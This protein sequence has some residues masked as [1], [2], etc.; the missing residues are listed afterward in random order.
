MLGTN[1]TPAPTNISN[2]LGKRQYE[3]SNHLGNVQAVVLDFKIPVDD[4]SNSTAN[5]IADYYIA[6][7]V[8]AQ[9]YYPFGMIMPARDFSSSGYRYGFNSEEKDDE[10]KG[11]GNSY[12]FKFRIYDPRL[13]KFLSIDPFAKSYAWNSPYAFAEN[14]V[15]RAIDLEGLEKYIVTARAFIPMEKVYNPQY[16]PCISP[17]IPCNPTKYF[18]GD[19]RNFYSVNS[20]A[21][22]TEQKV[23]V[24]F[25]N[26]T[27]TKLNNTAS[28]ST[29]LAS[30]GTT[31][32]QTSSLGEAGPTPTYDKPALESGTS[33][34]VYL[35]VNASNKLAPGA[36]SIDYYLAVTITP[37]VNSDGSPVLDKS[38]NQTFDYKI[39]GT[40]DGFPAYELWIT[41]EK[42]GNSYLLFNRTPTQSGEGPGSLFPPMEHQYSIT[43]NSSTETP[44][45]QVNFSDSKN[46]EECTGDGCN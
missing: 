46:S 25:E 2:L 10:V 43:G 9:D 8:N 27:A 39:Q 1:G 5:G 33:T 45:T 36:P 22:R 28:S 24:D 16:I 34:T 31:V 17:Y 30:D 14:D 21:Y 12:I 7:I 41:D 11:V 42:S 3:I 20:T 37:N 29:G 23:K 18:A 44:A 26:K 4:G 32:T 38:G 40:T 13:G 19:N 15:I 6:N 35:T